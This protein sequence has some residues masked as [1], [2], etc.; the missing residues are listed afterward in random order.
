MDGQ[1]STHFLHSRLT[2]V[3]HF[4]SSCDFLQITKLEVN[5]PLEEKLSLSDLADYPPHIR[6]QLAHGKSERPVSTLLK[7]L[8]LNEDCSFEVSSD[9]ELVL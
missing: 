9:G 6:L 1:T 3:L 5:Y 2:T 7:I 8:G 4:F